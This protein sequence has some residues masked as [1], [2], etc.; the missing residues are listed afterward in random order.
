MNIWKI[1]SIIFSVL[2]IG[3]GI[4]FYANFKDVFLLKLEQKEKEKLTIVL[5]DDSFEYIKLRKLQPVTPVIEKALTLQGFNFDS[6]EGT[7]G[8]LLNTTIYS[9]P[10][11]GKWAAKLL[12]LLGAG[13]IRTDKKLV[14]DKIK[15]E[16]GIDLVASL[17][18]PASFN[19]Q[20]I[21]L[22]ATGKEEFREKVANI[23]NDQGLNI[24]HNFNVGNQP[25][26]LIT[27]PK[28]LKERA[29]LAKRTLDS[30][31]IRTNEG[32]SEVVITLGEDYLRKVPGR[33]AEKKWLKRRRPLSPTRRSPRSKRWLK[34]PIILTGRLLINQILNCGCMIRTINCSKF[35]PLPMVWMKTA[36]TRNRFR[37]TGRLRETFSSAR[38][39]TAVIGSLRV[40]KALT[41]LSSC[42]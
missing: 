29:E 2:I 37:T 30:G 21:L 34:T 31:E 7:D 32:L 12:L 13:R 28:A 1:L 5:V 35:T 26:T 17:S 3:V 6:R 42:A 18:K 41:A 33:Q 11:A 15:I 8:F 40:K 25:R 16:L 39:R 23:L 10:G 14:R 27:A 4:F 38:S 20:N 22:N 9:A 36:G 19:N 24:A